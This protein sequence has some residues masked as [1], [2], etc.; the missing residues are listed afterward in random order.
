M[1]DGYFSTEKLKSLISINTRLAS[2]Y[3]DP[4]LLYSTILESV[5]C[6]VECEAASLML[7]QGD[8]SLNFM[9]V[10]GPK[11]AEVKKI[12]VSPNSIAGWVA[13]HNEAQIV[14]NV[15]S[16]PRFNPSVQQ[17]TRY[18]T[19]NMIAFPMQAHGKCV[20][21]IELINK[22]SGKD[23]DQADL[24]VLSLMGEYAGKAYDN[25]HAN[26][27]RRMQIDALQSAV[28]AG[29]GHHTFVARNPKILK[30]LED[31]DVIAKTNS[32][33][34][35]YGE[36]GVGKE[37]F[38]EQIQARSSRRD[39]PFV[40][41]SC[42]A[43]SHTLLESELFGHVRGAFTSAVSNQKGRFELA[44]GGTIFLDE[45]GELPLDLQAKL[46][47]VIQERKFE[48][49]GSSET[50]SV[51]VRIIAATN[52]NLEEMVEQRTFRGD[53]YFRLNVMPIT[54]PPLRERP[55]DLEPLCHL[56]MSRFARETNKY[57]SGFS[58]SALKA[59]MAYKWP[60]NVRELE[61]TVERACILGVP[62]L[63]EV[64]DLHLPT[65]EYSAGKNFS[66]AAEEALSRE[67]R[68]LRAAVSAF[69]KEYV[70]EILKETNWNQTKAA[71]ILGLQRTYVSKL[72]TEL[73][74]RR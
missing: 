68:S 48:R 57:F 55:E 37:L 32:S 28:S 39:K 69:K 9:V 34:L 33:V 66:Y 8:G 15:E 40:R 16:D 5:M 56:F 44:D 41:V 42:A 63:L 6:V 1:S 27:N 18:K 67:D 62:P 35:I 58:A 52:R 26:L 12:P 59:L 51:D 3:N 70:T 50:I 38:A 65:E 73:G 14:N 60:G 47:R 45:I 72:I 53:L 21:V 4:V 54:V 49:V 17:K 30:I 43:L 11:G 61:N 19:F 74:I 31:I 64:K 23:F 10:L 20:G 29:E 71:G 22:A 24:D 2:T 46:L 36:S 7:V 25:F 13:L